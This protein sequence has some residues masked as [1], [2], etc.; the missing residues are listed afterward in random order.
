MPKLK[1]YCPPPTEGQT[2]HDASP[3]PPLNL[4]VLQTA[5]VLGVSKSL[6]YV[7]M[8]RGDLAYIKI[9]ARRLIPVDGLMAFQ[10]RL[11]AQSAGA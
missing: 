9:G 2:E 4:S 8:E 7:F 1:P 11:V 5:G 10:R 6:V 3:I